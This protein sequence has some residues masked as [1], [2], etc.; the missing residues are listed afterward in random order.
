MCTRTNPGEE[1]RRRRTAQKASGASASVSEGARAAARAER[2]RRRSGALSPRDSRSIPSNL[3]ETRR[4]VKSGA[5]G[6]R[7]E[8][9]AGSRV[10][11][12][13]EAPGASGRVDCCLLF[14]KGCR[15]RGRW[16]A[17]PGAATGFLQCLCVRGGRDRYQRSRDRSKFRKIV[18]LR[19]SLFFPSLLAR[20]VQV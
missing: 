18:K 1:D 12:T 15:T 8:G 6:C 16:R 14:L 3:T 20:K 11:G 2:K 19:S 9:A 5:L 4:T 13:L 7:A 10:D 17:V